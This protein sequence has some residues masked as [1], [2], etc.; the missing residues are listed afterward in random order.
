MKNHKLVLILKTFS[1]KEMTRFREFVHSPYFNKHSGVRALVTYLDSVYPRFD[2]KRCSKMVL[3]K[4]L[5][6]NPEEGEKQLS[7]LFTYTLRLLDQFLIQEQFKEQTAQQNTM[8]LRSLRS[9]KLFKR[10]NRTLETAKTAMRNR[11]VQDS[12][13]Y[14]NQFLLAAEADE[15]YRQIE[16]RRK[17]LSIQQKQNS[18]DRFYIAEKLKDA[19]EMHVRS[20]ILKIDYATHLLEAVINE[21]RENEIIYAKE[22]SIFIYY[23]IY[24]MVL[25]SEQEYYFEALE[26]LEGNQERF[27]KPELKQIYNYFQNFCIEQIN[28]GEPNFLREVFELYKSQLEQELI[29]EE[30]LLSEWHYKNIVTTGLRLREMDWV[31]DFIESYKPR[32]RAESV[33]NAYIYNMAAYYHALGEYGK[34]LDL[35]IKVE[36]VDLRYSLGAKALLLRT[37]FELEEFESLYSLADS[38][39][40][41]VHRNKLMADSRRVGYLNLFKFTRRLGQLKSNLAFSSMDKISR[42]FDKL[43]GEIDTAIIFNKSWLLEKAETFETEIQ[44]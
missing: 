7:L 11:R 29:L 20:R 3:Y 17:D 26:T 36:Y 23:K 28:K 16:L 41:F 39:R 13:H 12:G 22:P 4:V 6:S 30:S 5:F 42:E 27:S 40:Q 31:R 19:C 38:F 15:Y 21:V 34:V 32:L 25:T 8:L 2:E 9:R 33:E 1:R 43:K 44:A 18:L 10:Y 24:Q 14:N 35:L 37:Y